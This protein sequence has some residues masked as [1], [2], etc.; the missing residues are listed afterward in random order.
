MAICHPGWGSGGVGVEARGRVTAAERARLLLAVPLLIVLGLGLVGCAGTAHVAA[1]VAT[2]VGRAGPTFVAVAAPRANG[3]EAPLESVLAL[4]PARLPAPERGCEHHEPGYVE[5]RFSDGRTVR[6]GD[7]RPRSIQWLQLAVIGEA[8]QWAPR[9]APRTPVRITGATAR[10]R[11][12]LGAV[13]AELRPPAIRSLALAPL[14]RPQRYGLDS[15]DVVLWIG[16][17]APLRADWEAALVSA[18]YAAMADRLG[19][20]HVGL[21]R[22]PTDGSR[23]GP[24]PAPAR[25]DAVRAVVAR[26]HVDVRELRREGNGVAITL[27]PRVVAE[28]LRYRASRFVRDLDRA[29]VKS[30]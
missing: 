27:R 10:E 22:C 3:R 18:T 17:C 24:S 8:H 28:F 15:G 4:V 20:R 26:L 19:L 9:A 14:P 6:Y 23:P 2:D 11:Q 21:W 7:C 29:G 30:L 1:I 12:A 13:L 5:I 25:L 16:G